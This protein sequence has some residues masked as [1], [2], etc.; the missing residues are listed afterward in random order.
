MQVRLRFEQFKS[1]GLENKLSESVNFIR[2]FCSIKF[3]TPAGWYKTKDAIIDTGAP[4]SLI[5][6]DVWNNSD[7]KILAEHRAYGINTKE[8]CTIPVKVGKVKC[9]LVDEEG[10]QSEEMEI[11]SY[12]ALT[13]TVPI[14]L[15]FKDL[16]ERFKLCFDFYEKE[17]WIEQKEREIK[18]EV[19]T[20]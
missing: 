3:K 20:H 13:N 18:F 5:P 1:S 7:V 16:L 19:L 14:I 17:A 10:N 4:I 15:G 11:L 9:I 12:L 6:L 2:L 8:E